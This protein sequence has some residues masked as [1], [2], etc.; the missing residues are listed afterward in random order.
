MPRM[1]DLIR[2]SAVPSNLVQSAAKGS[3]SLPVPEMLEIL[4]YLATQNKVFAEQAQLTLA[5]WDENSASTIAADPKTPTDV[6]DYMLVPKN[7]RAALLPALLSNPAVSEAALAKLAS[8]VSRAGADVISSSPRSASPLIQQ[9]LRVNPNLSSTSSAPPNDGPSA[10]PV[11]SASAD[12]ILATD[13]VPEAETPEPSSSDGDDVLSEE[14]TAYLSEHGDEIAAEDKP[15]QPIG[16]IH[17]DILSVEAEATAAAAGAGHDASAGSGK[18]FAAKKTYLSA[19][20]QRGSAL[21]KISR[22][23]VKGR[24]QV[25]MKGTKEERSILVRDGTKVVALAVLESP[26]VTDAE[27]EM[28]AS[29]KN[30]LEALLR[31]IT[32]KRRFMK[33]YNIVRNLTCNPRTPLDVSLGLMKN[34]HVNDLKTLSTNKDV[35]DTIRKLALKMYRQKKDPSN[36]KSE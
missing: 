8:R 1:L 35:S 10:N 36:R 17:E 6:L 14:V 5:S 22:L 27:V 30:V 18:A 3:L 15:F 7:L 2:A 16:G 25:A 26:K 19:E 13:S 9:A 21:Q 20:E 23:D 29:Q 34:L 33:D 32:M 28:F 11:A 4:V 12:D 24:I 31:G